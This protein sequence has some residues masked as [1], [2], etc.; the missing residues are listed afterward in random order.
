MIPA[1]SNHQS[2]TLAGASASA[3]SASLGPR[4]ACPLARVSW[5]GPNLRGKPPARVVWLP[6][7]IPY[8]LGQADFP[9][10]HSG[11]AQANV[12]IRYAYKPTGFVQTGNAEAAR[13]LRFDEGRLVM[14]GERVDVCEVREF[15]AAGG[16]R[17]Q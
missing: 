12:W 13:S 5:Q 1:P 15:F 9:G 7:G 11:D 10:P 8:N 16:R 4:L 17:K 6:R 3:R 14:A 2:V